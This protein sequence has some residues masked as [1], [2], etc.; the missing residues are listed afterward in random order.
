MIHPRINRKTR[1]SAW[2]TSGAPTKGDRR[3]CRASPFWHP[4]WRRINSWFRPL[5]RLAGRPSTPGWFYNWL[6]SFG[7]IYVCIIPHSAWSGV[8]HAFLNKFAGSRGPH[9]R[10]SF[11]L[12]CGRCQLPDWGFI[13]TAIVFRSC[14]SKLFNEERWNILIGRW[15]SRRCVCFIGWWLLGF[16]LFCVLLLV[17]LVL[18]ICSSKSCF[19][20][21]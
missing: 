5:R 14:E 12:L 10:A 11:G 8:A 19:V 16:F 6:R 20:C 15:K 2:L 7:P 17:G 9:R 3:L 13:G 21:Y 4:R 18:H 1:H